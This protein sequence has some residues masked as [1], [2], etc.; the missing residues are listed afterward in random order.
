MGTALNRG[1]DDRHKGGRREPP[2]RWEAA[3]MYLIKY[4]WLYIQLTFNMNQFYKLNFGHCRYTSSV[5]KW[6][7]DK[8]QAILNNLEVW[9]KI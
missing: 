8:T 1:G 3:T 7:F 6:L 9:G 4:K 5:Y 2:C